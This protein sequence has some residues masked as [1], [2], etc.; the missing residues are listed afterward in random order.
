M[1]L[2]SELFAALE[3]FDRAG[4]EDL[5]NGSA[6]VTACGGQFGYRQLGFGGGLGLRW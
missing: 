5:G 6:C 2:A 1:A 3:D 4:E